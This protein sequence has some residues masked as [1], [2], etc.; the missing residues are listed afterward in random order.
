MA[1]RLF[2]FGKR[3]K[4]VGGKLLTSANI[5]KDIHTFYVWRPLRGGG[6]GLGDGGGGARGPANDNTIPGP[7]WQGE[8]TCATGSGAP[9]GSG[10]CESPCASRHWHLPPCR[11]DR[12]TLREQAGGPACFLGGGSGIAPATSQP[13][14]RRSALPP[15]L[16]LLL[17]V[18]GLWGW[19]G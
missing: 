2:S 4:K 9:G 17:P 8:G 13:H 7:G 19:G 12:D 10:Q 11:L 5:K 3:K 18:T 6:A 14:S 16:L 1:F 15:W